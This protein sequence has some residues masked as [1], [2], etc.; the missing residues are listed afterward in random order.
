[1]TKRRA[2]G[3][4]RVARWESS[5]GTSVAR[6]AARWR[7]LISILAG[8][9]ALRSLLL[10]V[11]RVFVFVEHAGFDEDVVEEFPEVRDEG[12][13]LLGRLRT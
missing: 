12:L 10:R 8:G 4:R 7:V 1:M 11:K 6:D 2:R 9:F 3:S 5:V 13:P